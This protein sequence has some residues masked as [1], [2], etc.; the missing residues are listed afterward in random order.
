MLNEHLETFHQQGHQIDDLSSATETSNVDE[1]ASLLLDLVRTNNLSV[2]KSI[3]VSPGKFD[4]ETLFR[5]QRL[6]AL[7]GLS[8]ML[9]ALL[10]SSLLTYT[11]L[12]LGPNLWTLLDEA[13]N[14][15]DADTIAVLLRFIATDLKRVILTFSSAG[16]ALI[17]S[18][19][20]ILNRGHDEL[21]GLWERMMEELD[22][23]E[24]WNTAFEYAFSILHINDAV[25]GEQ[26]LKTLWR[27]GLDQ[28]KLTK[29]EISN[30]LPT[31]AH[32]SLSIPLAQHLVQLGVKIDHRR[33]IHNPTPLYN[34]AR[35]DSFKAARFIEFLLLHGADSSFQL[36]GRHIR[37]KKG[38]KGISTWLGMSW[39]EL[40]ERTAKVREEGFEDQGTSNG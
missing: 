15:E 32:Q 29:D 22:P 21:Y 38:P 4:Y 33:T 19:V 8:S 24:F 35:H 18:L 30:I 14:G 34:A 37:D 27:Q 39:D 3:L 31:I 2:V 12:I 23:W 11:D 26:F 7:L 10:A 25:G 28:K 40:V 6:A 20:Y 13:V 9:R 36:K 17:R 5:A 1:D 16:N